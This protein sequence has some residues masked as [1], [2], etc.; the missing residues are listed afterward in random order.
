MKSGGAAVVTLERADEGEIQKPKRERMKNLII[1]TPK[2]LRLAIEELAAAKGYIVAD[3]VRWILRD[4][5]VDLQKKWAEDL[6][7]HRRKH[8]K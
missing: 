2:E 4:G 5:V 8:R 7:R 3:L 1:R 6:E